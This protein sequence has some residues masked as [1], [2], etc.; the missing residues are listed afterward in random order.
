MKYA[1]LCE[2]NPLESIIFNYLATER[3]LIILMV[4]LFASTSFRSEHN[5]LQTIYH[6]VVISHWISI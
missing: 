1:N 5:M 4:S 6:C 3:I 2:F